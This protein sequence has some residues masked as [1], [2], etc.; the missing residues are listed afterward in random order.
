MAPLRTKSMAK[1][2][3]VIH[4]ATCLLSEGDCLALFSDGVTQAGIGNGLHQGWTADGVCREANLHMSRGV[5]PASLPRML[6]DKARALSGNRHG[7]D[8]SVLLARC[9]RGVVV[10]V[11]TGPPSDPSRDSA[12]VH[13]FLGEDGL[14]VVCG[15]TT[16]G[17]VARE[18]EVGAVVLPKTGSRIVPPRYAIEGIDLATEG[19]VCLNQLYNLMDDTPVLFEEDHAVRDLYELL[20]SADRIRF[21]VGT[22][23]NAASATTE[24]RQ[25]GILTRPRIVPLLAERLR[26][27]GKLIEVEYI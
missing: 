22:A 8:S 6:L 23:G 4:E 2:R 14:K 9:R 24:V 3:T 18:T 7:D 16:A 25:Q 5:A 1:G 12:V 21:T 13:E 27:M 20:V 11:L 15:G 17:I 19:A 26:A 10:N